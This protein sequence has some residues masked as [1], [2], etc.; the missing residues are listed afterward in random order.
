MI[1]ALEHGF[2][3][4]FKSPLRIPKT[5]LYKIP[6]EYEMFGDDEPSKVDDAI[7]RAKDRNESHID[8]N[9]NP[10][11]K[12]MQEVILDPRTQYPVRLSSS[13]SSTL[14]TSS[15]KRFAGIKQIE[16]SFSP[17]SIS[18]PTLRSNPAV[19]LSV[20]R[21]CHPKTNPLSHDSNLVLSKV[22]KLSVSSAEPAKTFGMRYPIQ[23]NK[24]NS[25]IIYLSNPF[26]F[27]W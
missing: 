17:S 15:K 23:S 12:I 20:K 18:S 9:I 4:K 16:M 1:E 21:P 10:P 6:D 26:T 5:A 14:E 2:F 7:R 24:S 22:E 8:H 3:S 27:T 11:L 25:N 13:Q 19:Q